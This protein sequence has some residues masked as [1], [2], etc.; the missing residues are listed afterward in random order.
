M[1][2]LGFRHENLP[3]TIPELLASANLELEAVYTHF[4]TADEPE[5]PLFDEQRA[6][7][8]EGL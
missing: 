5:H 6:E 7:L 3:W 4:A 2:R 8:R 1:H